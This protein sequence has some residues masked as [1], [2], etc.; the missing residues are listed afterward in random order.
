M[1]EK[2]HIVTVTRRLVMPLLLLVLMISSQI[3]GAACGLRCSLGS[4]CHS[5]VTSGS[6][7]QSPAMDMAA[8][9][10]AR[11][12]TH[13]TGQVTCTHI[14]AH[15]ELLAVAQRRPGILSSHVPPVYLSTSAPFTDPA[16]QALAHLILRGPPPLI[17]QRDPRSLA[18]LPLR[19]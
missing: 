18:S 17:R 19:V 9:H 7:R 10:M 6:T 11:P 1:S 8:C 16:H 5:R 3:T 14:C 15:P 2:H 4:S 12:G 13:G